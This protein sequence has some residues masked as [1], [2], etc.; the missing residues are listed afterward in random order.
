VGQLAPAN[1]LAKLDG[2]PWIS[3]IPPDVERLYEYKGDVYAVTQD[4][5]VAAFYYNKDVF[6]AAHLAVPQTFSELVA[7]CATLRNHG[8]I[9]MDLG[10]QAGYLNSLI[11]IE[12][13]NDIVYAQDPN[14]GTEILSGKVSFA[15]SDVWRQAVLSANEKYAALFSHNCIQ[16][17]STATTD[18]EAIAAVASG[19]AAMVNLLGLGAQLY[20]DNPH[21]NFGT[22]A[23]PALDTPGK[24]VVTTDPTHSYSV[25]ARSQHQ[26]EAKEFIAYLATSE[27]IDYVS[28]AAGTIPDVIP[29][30]Y[31]L[32]GIYDGISSLLKE[33]K[34]ALFPT[35][36]WPNYKTKLTWQAQAQLIATGSTTPLAATNEIMKTF[37]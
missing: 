35:T 24:A 22:F 31:A 1:K 10:N 29:K 36:Y 25:N 19:K 26:A 6:D 30:D 21:G 5:T 18:T 27:S 4:Q 13:A 34:T 14:F 9:P 3:K 20:I 37:S 8:V 2:A 28:K 15:T 17:N 7:S 33:G 23:A 11:P 16:P 32:P 12:F